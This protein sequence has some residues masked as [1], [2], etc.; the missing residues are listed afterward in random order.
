MTVE[1]VGRWARVLDDLE[2]DLVEVG[3][4]LDAG[5]APTHRAWAP[6]TDLGP[7]PPALLARAQEIAEKVAEALQRSEQR[8]GELGEEL[9]G[10]DRR[11][12]A[13]LAYADEQAD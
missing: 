4:A 12:R 6:P 3:R 1:A 2:A 9:A 10:V 11:R 7:P 8:L 13:G 5:E